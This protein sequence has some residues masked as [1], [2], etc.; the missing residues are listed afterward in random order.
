MKTLPSQNRTLTMINTTFTNSLRRARSLWHTPEAYDYRC[1]STGLRDLDRQLPKGGWPVGTVTELLPTH[2]GIGE[3][4]LLIPTLARLTQAGKK[5]VLMDS[6][7]LPELESLSEH[8][9]RLRQVTL[10]RSTEDACFWAIE[11]KLQSGSV[12]L[13]VA[14]S[15]HWSERQIRR[16][17]KAAAIGN[18]IAILYHFAGSPQ[19]SSPA[20]LR[21]VLRP[22]TDGLLDIE[23]I[24]PRGG[25]P[26]RTFAQ[27]LR[28]QPRTFQGLY[29]T[30]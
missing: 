15:Q 9:V 2:A 3:F 21:L 28:Q 20:V 4:S 14:W 26:S 5:V 23:I 13:L 27:G 10:L 16:L 30:A 11:Q 17:Q 12:G 18:C 22:G 25:L 7:H 24:K 29:A 8:G 6:A 1:E 19:Q